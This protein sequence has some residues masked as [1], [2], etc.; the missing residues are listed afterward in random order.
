VRGEA[1]NDSGVEGMVTP[2]MAGSTRT[3]LGAKRATGVENRT[4]RCWVKRVM[5]A[6]LTPDTA[7]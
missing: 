2:D 7:G 1:S 3:L 6:G 4:R 5:I